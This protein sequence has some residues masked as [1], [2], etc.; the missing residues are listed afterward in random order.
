MQASEAAAVLTAAALIDKRTIGETE[1]IMWAEILPEWI[2]KTD[3][4]AAVAVHYRATRDWLMPVDVITRVKAVRA[5]RFRAAGQPDL[6][7]GLDWRDEQRWRTHWRDLVG[8][9]RPAQ[10]AETVAD[11]AMGLPPRHPATIA[12]DDALRQ[13]ETAKSHQ[14][15]VE[16]RK[17]EWSA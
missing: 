6:P 13:I 3:A 7:A 12:Q 8:E 15:P 11:A 10:E 1:A 17:S 9:G 5:E 4:L 16:P 14:P 2:T